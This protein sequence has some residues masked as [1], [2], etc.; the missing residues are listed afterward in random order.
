MSRLNLKT[1]PVIDRGIADL[2]TLEAEFAMA[3]KRVAQ[4]IKR[5]DEIMQPLKVLMRTKA[6]SDL[7]KRGINLAETIVIVSQKS[8]LSGEW[9]Y[10]KA[11]VMDVTVEERWDHDEDVYDPALLRPEITYDFAAVKK[12]GSPSKG[13]SGINCTAT[14]ERI[15]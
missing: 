7:N 14:I 3:S 10:R 8:W 11:I 1:L 13:N 2:E 12:D 6:I 9:E 4:A 15:A 5:R